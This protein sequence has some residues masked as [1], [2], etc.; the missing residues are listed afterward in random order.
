MQPLVAHAIEL[1]NRRTAALESR[2]DKEA[3]AEVRRLNAA[4]QLIID[5]KV[6]PLPSDFYMVRS[7]TQATKLYFVAEGTCQCA[8]HRSNRGVCSH[9]FAAA[10]HRAAARL[11]ALEE[12]RRQLEGWADLARL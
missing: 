9:R 8:F 4:L 1:V 6:R 10:L 3:Q 7:Q 12:E 11:Q 5:E 2:G